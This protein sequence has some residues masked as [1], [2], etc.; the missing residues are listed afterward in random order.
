M[1]L[2]LRDFLSSVPDVRR[3]QGRRWPLPE[4]LTGTLLGVASGAI[5]YRKLHSFFEARLEALNGLF[6]TCGAKAPSYTG[7]RQILQGLDGEMLEA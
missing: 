7:L 6:G 2:N 5:S 4:I 1:I 3:R